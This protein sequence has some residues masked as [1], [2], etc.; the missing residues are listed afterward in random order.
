M[1]AVALQAE[2]PT[3]TGAHG[4]EPV[5]VIWQDRPDSSGLTLADMGI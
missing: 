3:C 2:V 5:H 1:L 4:E